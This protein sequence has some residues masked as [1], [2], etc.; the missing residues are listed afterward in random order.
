MYSP[1]TGPQPRLA[2][3]PSVI[4]H[5]PEARMRRCTA[6]WPLGAPAAPYTSPQRRGVFVTLAFRAGPP[7]A[8]RGVTAARSLPQPGGRSLSAVC[9]S[10]RAGRS[11]SAV[12]GGGWWGGWLLVFAGLPTVRPILA[13][14][15]VSLTAATRLHTRTYK[16]YTNI[17][18]YTVERGVR[19]FTVI[20]LSYNKLHNNNS[21]RQLSIGPGT[22][23]WNR[24][25]SDQFADDPTY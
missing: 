24:L 1:L 15:A 25:G 7:H 4:F 16:L 6:A 23:K 18:G 10:Q 17:T 19:K 14:E 3:S 11:L 12:C 9:C 13:V 5:L 22:K 2:V 21:A 20:C 8:S